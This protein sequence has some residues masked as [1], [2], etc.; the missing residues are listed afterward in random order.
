MLTVTNEIITIK[1]RPKISGGVNTFLK[2]YFTSLTFALTGFCM[3]P[4]ITNKIPSANNI[5]TKSHKIT[6]S[7]INGLAKQ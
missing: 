3:Q 4:I 5:K 7:C 2:F 6:V 1:R